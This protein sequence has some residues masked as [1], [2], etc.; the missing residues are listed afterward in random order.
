MS[1]GVEA[2]GWRIPSARTT[3]GT[4][5]YKGF[6]GRYGLT[7]PTRE[8]IWS[9]Y[10]RSGAVLFELPTV[11][12]RPVRPRAV[13]YGYTNGYTTNPGYWATSPDPTS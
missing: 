13:W 8:S 5:G 3:C 11:L 9:R 1:I 12:V 6:R 7:V 10:V 4:L 2:A